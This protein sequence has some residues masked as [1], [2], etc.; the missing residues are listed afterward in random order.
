MFEGFKDI[1]HLIVLNSLVVTVIS[2][3]LEKIIPTIEK[4]FLFIKQN[5]IMKG[6]VRIF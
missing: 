1:I 3:G 4:D 5:G 2:L 6:I